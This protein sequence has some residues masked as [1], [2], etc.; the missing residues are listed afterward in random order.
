MR[1]STLSA[2]I[3]LG[4]LFVF[5]AT[6]FTSSAKGRGRGGN[7]A[8]ATVNGVPI[9]REAFEKA[10]VSLHEGVSEEETTVRKTQSELLDRLINMELFIQESKNIGLDQLDEVIKDIA[11]YQNSTLRQM[12]YS[13]HIR[14]I[15]TPDKKE[16]GKLYRESIKEVKLSSV[17]INTEEDARK[18]QDDIKSGGNFES[19]SKKLASEGKAKGG[20]E[21]VYIKHKDLLPEVA[22]AISMIE[23]GAI[24]SIVKIG[25]G[26]SISML[27]DVRFPENSDALALAREEALKAKKLRALK[28]YSEALKKKYVKL[29]RKL[30][31]GLDY[32]VPEPDY[33]TLMRDN[34]I[35]A[36][37]KG[38]KQ[39][40]V[41]SLSESLQK[42]FF[43]GVERASEKK[44]V[45]RRKAEVLD[46]IVMKTV[47]EMEA[48]RLKIDRMKIYKYKV[49][50]YRRSILFGTFIRNV[51]VPGIKVED[52][53]VKNYFAEHIA[54]YTLPGSLK[55]KSLVFVNKE[56]ALDAV[57]K[58]R[59]GADFLWIMENASGQV[60]KDIAVNL[61]KFDEEALPLDEIPNDVRK[62][63]S[64]ANP[65]DFRIYTSPEGHIYV[66][67]I[68]DVTPSRPKPFN[69]VEGDIK[70][71]LFNKNLQIAI[72][73]YAA[74]LR[75][76]SEI[77]VL[78]GDTQIQDIISN[79]VK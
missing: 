33:G 12:L 24:T 13:Y 25:N 5:F 29:D 9:T 6:G 35:I 4:L 57:E 15:K 8:L 74:K 46:E 38:G 40:T 55:I 62:A 67:Y 31:D 45:N 50:E 2:S 20:Q 14:G 48:K 22:K 27:E 54:D 32:D 7:V 71:K 18:F 68:R 26:F 39:V 37:I 43:H 36:R 58:L 56:Y 19:L 52:E 69:S 64:G 42:K 34:R 1:K 66:F 59:K 76:A 44:K 72:E 3:A 17:L 51:I 73:E 10:L 28:A 23:I 65:G 78:A 16:V 77:K 75:A 47:Y 53:E 49:E 11:T 21:G 79:F 70:S 61:L 63:V 60:S 30:L 41:S